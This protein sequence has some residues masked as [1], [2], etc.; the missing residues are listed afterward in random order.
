MKTY[1]FPFRQ[2][3]PQSPCRPYVFVKLSNPDTDKLVAVYALIDTGADE[4]ALPAAYASLL[5]H[6]LEKGVVR[7]I[8][9]GNGTTFAY[10]HTSSI[11]MADFTTGNI[12]ID[13][14]PN[15]RIPL[16]G[17]KSFLSRFSVHIDYPR[18]EYSL[19]LP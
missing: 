12:T 10:S 1:T 17:V 14:M 8:G 5:G 15:L 16:L 6:H 3:T 9:T 19:V 11:T 13:Y 7:K 18:E 4:C 2:V